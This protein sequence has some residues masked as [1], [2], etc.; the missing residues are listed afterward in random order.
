MF[1]TARTYSV[2]PGSLDVVMHRV[3][4]DFAEA[5]SQEPGFLSYQALEI[6]DDTIMT[7]S[8]FATLEQAQDSNALAARWV[9]EELADHDIERVG[10]SGGEVMVS[11]ASADVLVPEHH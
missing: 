5:L 6:G 8:V 7:I 1:A 2:A 11:R 4:R 3:D 10:V 9:M